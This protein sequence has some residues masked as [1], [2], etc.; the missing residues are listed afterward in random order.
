MPV[1]Q[2]SQLREEPDHYVLPLVGG[3]VDQLNVDFAFTLVIDGAHS[4]RIACP[5]RYHDGE[6]EHHI[7][8]S[9]VDQL[10]PLLHLHQATVLEATAS[11]LGTLVVHFDAG[12]SIVVDPDVDYEA[13]EVNGGMPPI[14]PDYQ[15]VCLPGGG[16]DADE[17]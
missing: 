15:L 8:P 6:Q 9:D 14:T 5:M 2:A 13:W 4:V 3:T 1:D 11:K 16:V 12:R 7:D 17:G 10:L